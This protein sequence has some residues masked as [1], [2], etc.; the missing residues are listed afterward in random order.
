MQQPSSGNHVLSPAV[1]PPRPN[2]LLYRRG[3]PDLPELIEAE[4]DEGTVYDDMSVNTLSTR[5]SASTSASSREFPSAVNIAALSVSTIPQSPKTA[6]PSQTRQTKLGHEVYSQTPPDSVIQLQNPFEYVPSNSFRLNPHQLGEEASPP[7]SPSPRDEALLNAG[8]GFGLGVN[9]S[10]TRN[11]HQDGS[12]I[13]QKDYFESGIQ[14][15]V[16]GDD[17]CNVDDCRECFDIQATHHSSFGPIYEGSASGEG[18]TET[19]DYMSPP[20]SPESECKIQ[21]FVLANYRRRR[22][23]LILRSSSTVIS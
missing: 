2:R 11:F 22:S 19:G 15:G 20:S 3:L 10:A 4:E 14:S 7:P 18:I 13:N 21:F 9:I 5:H 16:Y 1:T 8:L 23:R 12:G 6:I 17:T